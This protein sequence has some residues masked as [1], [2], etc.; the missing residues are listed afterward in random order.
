M[1]SIFFVTVRIYSNKFKHN[2]L[3]NKKCFLIFS[4]FLKSTSKSKHF[5]NKDDPHGLCMSEIAD[6]KGLV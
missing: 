5:E 4:P 6:C 2:Y 3:E 1:K